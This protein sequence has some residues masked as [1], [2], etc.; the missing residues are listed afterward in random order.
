MNNHI[1]RYV[2]CFFPQED[3]ST[4]IR[5]LNCS[6]LAK[7]IACPHITFSYKPEFVDESLFGEK[8]I[9]RAVGYGNDGRNE[10]LKVE[11]VSASPKLAEAFQNIAVPHITL[12]I[13]N[14]AEPVNTR[15]LVFDAI[16]PFEL[17]GVYG[18]YVVETGKAVTE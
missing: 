5:P 3:L 11:L 2:G 17:T 14:D 13:S 1:Y 10:G 6:P 16:E 18:G 12:S 9:V 8:L 4:Y 7:L 15:Y